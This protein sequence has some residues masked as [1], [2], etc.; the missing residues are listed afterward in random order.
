MRHLKNTQLLILS[1]WHFTLSAQSFL[2]TPIEGKYGR[3]FIIVNYVDWGKDQILDHHC[4]SKTYSGHQGT[5]FVI[6]NFKAMDSGVYVLATAKGVVTAVED[7]LFDREKVADKSK[8]LGNYLAIK[9]DN[10]YFSYYAHLKKNSATVKVGDRV[11][12]GQKIAAV[13]SSGNS[14]DP[15][16]HFELWWDSLFVVD[17]FAG[18][19]GNPRSLWIAPLPYDDKFGVWT[20]GLCNF[21]PY[22]DT[23]REEPPRIK[24]F[25]SMD[26]AIGYWAIL[27]GIRAADELKVKWYDPQGKEWFE[28]EYIVPYHAWYFYFWTYIDMPNTGKF[29]QWSARLFRNG[30]E[31]ETVDFVVDEI[32]KIEDVGFYPALLYPNPCSDFVQIKDADEHSGYTVLDAIGQV[33]VRGKGS[34]IDVSGLPRGLYFVQ[35]GDKT[36]KLIK[37]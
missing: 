28:F 13:G 2:H 19:C 34:K 22:L 33:A 18:H 37:Q 26:K 24:R 12:E 4:G 16:L 6:R 30:E 32:S 9:H 29:G 11:V 10:G 27:F 25:S 20:S 35:I 36:L 1:C 21:V 23:L 7:K 5:D 15:H 31:I 3:D 14:S 8:G 17:P